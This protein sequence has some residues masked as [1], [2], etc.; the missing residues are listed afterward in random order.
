M[1]AAAEASD[2]KWTP[3][4]VLELNAN[5]LRAKGLRLPPSRLWDPKRG[6]GLLA[7]A[8]NVDGCSG[9]FVSKEGLVVTNHHC[10]FPL[11]QEHSTPERDLIAN[12]F[13]A[14]ARTEEPAGKGVRI[15]V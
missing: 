4:Q 9:A 11:L 6:T 10:V 7:G 12:G 13:V 1:G 8:V 14:R 15:E 5:E 3:K 2:G